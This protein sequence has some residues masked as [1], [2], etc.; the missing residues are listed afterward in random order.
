MSNSGF[1]VGL[2][3][4]NNTPNTHILL[5]GAAAFPSVLPVEGERRA[6]AR[7]RRREGRGEKLPFNTKR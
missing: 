5:A 4:T 3:H 2:T 6:C 7:E 1:G